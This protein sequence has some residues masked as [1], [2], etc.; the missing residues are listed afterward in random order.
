MLNNFHHWNWNY[1]L[2][3]LIYNICITLQEKKTRDKITKKERKWKSSWS[4]N[5]GRCYL[6]PTEAGATHC[7]PWLWHSKKAFYNHVQCNQPQN[8][9]NHSPIH[10]RVSFCHSRSPHTHAHTHAPSLPN[11]YRY[12]AS[13]GIRLIHL[14]GTLVPSQQYEEV[15]GREGGQFNKREGG[16]EG[17]PAEGVEKTLGQESLP[18]TWLSDESG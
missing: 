14:H 16:G 13:S 8:E 11:T 12:R 17:N 4:A 9:H 6:L 15:R 7:Y 3:K 1:I 10:T 2:V 18:R 5:Q